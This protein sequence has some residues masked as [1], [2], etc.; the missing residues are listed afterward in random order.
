MYHVCANKKTKQEKINDRNNFIIS[1]CACCVE[2]FE[3]KMKT[4][5]KNS[6][7][8]MIYGRDEGNIDLIKE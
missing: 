2:V 8:L 1:C 4:S 3:S 6:Y 7:Q 5:E